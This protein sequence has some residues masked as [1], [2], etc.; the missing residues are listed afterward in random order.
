MI[1]SKVINVLKKLNKTEIRELGDFVNSP[2]HN[3]NKNVRKLFILLKAFYPLFENKKLTKEFIYS[4]LFAGKNYSDKTIRNLNS[5]LLEL[6]E[7]YLAY[8]FISKNPS[9]EKNFRTA[10]LS[11]KGLSGL[12]ESSIKEADKLFKN[13]KFD[14]GN[15]FYLMHLNEM[16]KDFLAIRKNKLI[17]LNMKEGEYLVYAFLS[18]YLIFKMKFYNY[19]YKLGTEK[20]SEF[21]EQFEKSINIESFV[22]H[23]ENISSPYAEIILIYYYCAKFMS[24]PGD[25]RYYNKTKA[26]FAKNKNFL[27]RTEI[28]NIY[29][30]FN[31]YCIAK[32]RSGESRYEKDL[33]ELYK[34][35]IE[36]KLILGEGEQYLHITIFN[37][38]VTIGL[39]LNELEWTKNFV[40]E[41][42]FYLIPEYKDTMYNYSYSQY[43]FRK[44][45][46]EKSL[47]CMNNV[48]F[49]NYTIKSGVRNLLLKIY[50]ELKYTE[51]FFSLS[52]SMKHYLSNDKMLPE[53][54]REQDFNFILHTNKLYKYY[55][56]PSRGKLGNI[57]SEIIE[58][59]P[60]AHEGWLHEK[61][62][63]LNY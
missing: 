52:D 61:I 43:Y 44:K 50:F 2:Y 4:K 28:I 21:V 48:N 49:E 41:Y 26:L 56:D 6:I 40:E 14:G 27:D 42:T 38:I 33:F 12:V 22:K 25:S 46:F 62:E 1:K 31:G 19:K 51:S 17:N 16:E 10:A 24:E 45:E 54:K 32:M 63:E 7:K 18:K 5:D 3:R 30:T 58:K 53:D 15:I 39:R 9:L 29:L 36:E 13:F 8:S 23:L 20:L 59:S 60:G 34:S 47:E 11:D 55:L 37:N 35:M 57:K